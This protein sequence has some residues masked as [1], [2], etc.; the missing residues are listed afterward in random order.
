M[1]ELFHATLQ[2]GLDQVAKTHKNKLSQSV[3]VALKELKAWLK[4]NKI[5]TADALK[6][7]LPGEITQESP[8][9]LEIQKLLS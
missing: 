6:T 3:R 9:A 4:S 1:T 2:H 8:A 5:K 7:W